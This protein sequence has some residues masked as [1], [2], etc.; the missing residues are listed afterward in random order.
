MICAPDAVAKTLAAAQV[1]KNGDTKRWGSWTIE[2]VPAYNLKRG[3]APGQFYHEKGQGN[4]YVLGY[5]GKRFYFS[6]DTE[7]T[8]EMAALKNIDVAVVCMNMPYTMPP[9]EAAEA[10]KTFRPKVAIPYHYS[11][12]GSVGVPKAIAGSG[13]EVRLLEFIPMGRAERRAVVA[14]RA[15][16]GPPLVAAVVKR[17]LPVARKQG[18][19]QAAPR[20]RV[21]AQVPQ[22][23]RRV[24]PAHRF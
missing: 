23:R 14:A 11:G 2:A 18:A 21:A 10:V 19:T 8:P 9:E 22:P 1:M 3:P 17:A 24:N 4:G 13:V 15:G 7:G 5:G 6:G 20:A 12:S 16:R